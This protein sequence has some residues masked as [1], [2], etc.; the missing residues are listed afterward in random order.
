MLG[1][2]LDTGIYATSVA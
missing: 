2:A 1:N